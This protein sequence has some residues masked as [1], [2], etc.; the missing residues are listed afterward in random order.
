M[1]EKDIIDISKLI[2]DH[3]LGKVQISIV[4]WLSALMMLEGFDVQAMAF[5]APAIIKQW[6][7]SRAVFGPVLSAS[8]FGLMVGALAFTVASDMLGR[9]KVIVTGTVVLG[10]FSLLTVFATTP[11]ELMFL[12]FLAGLGL[13]AAFPTGISLVSE[14]VPSK[15]R[16]TI[17]GIIYVGYTLGASLGGL[18]VAWTMQVFGWHSIFY[19]GG[20]LPLIVAVGLAYKLPESLHF[21]ILKKAERARI[22][23]ILQKLWPDRDFGATVQFVVPEN[24]SR[25]SSFTSLFTERRV[26]MTLLLWVAFIFGYVGHHFLTGW[27][28]TILSDAGF[29]IREAVSAASIYQLGGT[30][31]GFLVGR[32]LDRWGRNIV[33]LSYVIAIPFLVVLGAASSIVSIY[34]S[35]FLAGIFLL[36]AQIGIATIATSCYP[37]FMRSTG[38]GWAMGIGRIGSIAGPIIGGILL[39]TGISRASLLVWAGTPL[40]GSAAAIVLLGMQ[41]RRRQ[42]LQTISSAI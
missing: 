37:T 29:S 23:A 30:I 2:E 41:V 17:V 24:P 28:P 31:G 4:I 21:L 42:T 26:L 13:G 7:A 15:M 22:V 39:S 20:L 18:L 9:K 1:V 5:A 10:L 40:L 11:W 32:A 6:G 25:H 8:L 35:V 36:G 3:S 19:I 12:R 16:G 38:T 14:Y 34:V 33:A 27:L